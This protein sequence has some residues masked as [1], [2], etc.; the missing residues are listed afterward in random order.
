MAIPLVHMLPNSITLVL[1][2]S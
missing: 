1:D 2:G